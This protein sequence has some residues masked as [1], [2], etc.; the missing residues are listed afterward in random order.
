MK[1]FLAGIIQGS[2]LGN[3]I[4]DQS[5]R[6]RIRAVLKEAFPDAVI[7]SPQ[8]EHPNSVMY[9]DSKGQEV[10]REIMEK[11]GKTDLLIAYLPEASMGTAIEMW[12]AFNANRKVVAITPMGNN[13]CVKYLSHHVCE[14]LEDFEDFAR[15]GKLRSLLQDARGVKK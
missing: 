12:I 8:E 1:I 10:F 6:K 9:P 5:Y 4:H 13:W 3:S 2:E 7:Y 15:S 11:A 14:N